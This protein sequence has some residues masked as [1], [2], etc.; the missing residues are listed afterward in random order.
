[1][2]WSDVKT[3]EDL[4][5]KQPTLAEGLSGKSLDFFYTESPNPNVQWEV[6]RKRF[7]PE[8]L[9]LRPN[10]EVS[11]AW[12]V[13]FLVVL[14]KLITP[15]VVPFVIPPPKPP[16]ATDPKDLYIELPDDDRAESKRFVEALNTATDVT[17]AVVID[18]AAVCRREQEELA[19]DLGLSGG[20][21]G[22]N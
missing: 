8:H 15:R 4:R 16:P 12:Y 13:T 3:L 11:R 21:F 22:F 19:A 10:Q 9:I 6:E 18:A 5:A 1:M 7:Q 14:D 20:K 2:D 17:N